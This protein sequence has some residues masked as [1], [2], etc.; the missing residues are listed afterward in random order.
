MSTLNARVGWDHV[1]AKAVTNDN[2]LFGSEGTSGMGMGGGALSSSF[3]PGSGAFSSV[4]ASAGSRTVRTVLY[5]LL[6]II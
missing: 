1:N 5:S 2:V 4:N 3:A 6:T